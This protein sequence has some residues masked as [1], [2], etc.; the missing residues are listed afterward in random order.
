MPGLRQPSGTAFAIR[1]ALPWSDLVGVVRAAEDAGYSTLFV[2]EIVARDAF[3]MLGALAGET[4]DLM[5]GTGIVPMRSRTPLLTA[6]AGVTVQERSGGR[7]L[8][9]LGTGDVGRGALDEL[10]EV[11]LAVRVLLSGGSADRKGR[12]VRLDLVP[13]APVPIW[14]S[15]LGPRAIRLAGEIADGVLLNWCP[16]E[17]VAFAREAI[18]EGA[19]A[20]GRDPS[21]IVIGVYV[22]CWAG[23]EA[24]EAE[25]F[26]AMQ[27]ASG[28]YASFPAYARQLDQVGLGVEGAVAAEAHRAGRPDLV[29]EELVHAVCAFGADAAERLETYRAA[30]ADLPVLYPVVVAGDPAASLEATLLHLA[31]DRSSPQAP[32]PV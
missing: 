11:V 20:A 9:G 4:R 18:A 5:L 6:M 26:L 17:R 14:I 10:R 30:G 29:P 3:V 21:E 1:D 31:P 15:A 8:L 13:G 27:R 28:E 12:S 7:L 22:R 24:D 2:P 19:N 32:H 23:D 16:P 25:A